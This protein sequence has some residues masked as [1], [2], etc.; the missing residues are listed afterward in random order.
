MNLVMIRIYLGPAGIE[1]T[2]PSHSAFCTTMILLSYPVGLMLL[3]GIAYLISNWRTLQLIFFS[4]LI[5]LVGIF[6][7]S[8]FLWSNNTSLERIVM[9]VTDSG[10]VSHSGFSQSLPAG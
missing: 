6:Y 10:S 9:N 3:P 1:W 8:A 2:D 7:W 5:L 4:P